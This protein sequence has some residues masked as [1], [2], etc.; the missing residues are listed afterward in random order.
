MR[1]CLPA[2]LPAVLSGEELT[3]LFLFGQP[4]MALEEEVRLSHYLLSHITDK[5]VRH[6]STSD[7]MRGRL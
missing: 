7:S 3:D 2:C 6:A 1:L 5:E 4:M